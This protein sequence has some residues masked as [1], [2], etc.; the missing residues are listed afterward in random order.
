[1]TTPLAAEPPAPATSAR[2]RAFAVLAAAAAGP[3]VLTACD[4]PTPIATVTVGTDSVHSEA[5]CYNEGDEPLS[6]E[7]VKSCLTASKGIKT[8]KVHADETVRFGV[9]PDI[10]DKGWAL[11]LNGQPIT[12]PLKRTY[13]TVPG[14]VFFNQQYGAQGDSTTVSIAKGDNQKAYGLWSFKLTKED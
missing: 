12:E 3:L 6:T 14:S 13:T 4:K 10:A 9:E 2:R 11:L 7:Q 5:E 8:I 1:M